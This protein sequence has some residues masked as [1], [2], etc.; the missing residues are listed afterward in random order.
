MPRS[1]AGRAMEVDAE[2]GRQAGVSTSATS[3]TSYL[4][5]RNRA[6]DSR[7]RQEAERIR[8][9]L[10][11][12][13]GYVR[14]D[15]V[16]ARGSVFGDAV[17]RALAVNSWVAVLLFCACYMISYLIFGLFWWTIDLWSSECVSLLDT[18]EEAL[19]YSIETQTTI[20]YGSK[21]VQG[22]C[23]VGIFLLFTQS[24][25]GFIMDT[26]L[27]GLLF[28]KL[29]KPSRS[30]IMLRVSH[31]VCV[32]QRDGVLKLQIRVGDMRRRGGLTKVE[33]RLIMVSRHMTEEGEYIPYYPQKLE[34]EEE[35]MAH[36]PLLFLPWTLTHV[37]DQSSPLYGLTRRDLEAKGTEL[38]FVMGAELQDLALGLE[39]RTSFLPKEIFYGHRFV[40]CV[41]RRT[42]GSSEVD[43]T[44]FDTHLPFFADGPEVMLE[45][46]VESEEGSACRSS[47]DGGSSLVSNDANA[48]EGGSSLLSSSPNRFSGGLGMQFLAIQRQKSSSS[49]TS[50]EDIPVRAMSDEP[51]AREAA[52]ATRK[53]A[54]SFPRELSLLPPSL[55]SP[56]TAN[57]VATPLASD[58]G[59]DTLEQ[60]L[61]DEITTTNTDTA[62]AD[63]TKTEVGKT[64]VVRSASK[65]RGN[66]PNNTLVSRGPSMGS[67]VSSSSFYVPSLL[68]DDLGSIGSSS[69]TSCAISAR[70]AIS[71]STSNVDVSA[72]EKDRETT[73]LEERRNRNKGDVRLQD[74]ART[75]MRSKPANSNNQYSH[76]PVSHAT[77]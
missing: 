39:F 8:G 19:L 43:W 10:L 28:A 1:H 74:L 51:A 36:A 20:G 76:S 35:A 27:F 48:G 72:K 18:F 71:T 14:G 38:V 6:D 33:T 73:T 77:V 16:H 12:K 65:H 9:G 24:T 40:N 30:V 42:D 2:V 66:R 11:N 31:D 4:R 41:K 46:L 44:V 54:K 29:T 3:M 26:V 37:I 22:E 58:S 56:P 21:H 7:K 69:S 70:G 49:G 34:L 75:P 52:E 25:L 63:A 67:A 50:E 47:T 59:G 57:A 60:E 45:D 5:R 64:L 15:Y 17:R 62:A 32:C 61:E 53:A 55:P 13:R 68:D 23:G